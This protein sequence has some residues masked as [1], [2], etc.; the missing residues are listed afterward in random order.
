M[1]CR[2][3]GKEIPNDSLICNYCGAHQTGAQQVSNS[4]DGP[5]GALGILCFLFPIL[6]LILYLVWKDPM[7]IKA[8]GAGKAALWGFIVGIVLWIIWVIIIAATASSG[9]Y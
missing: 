6:G 9:Y 4:N 1:F 5:I 2:N 7:P 8:K 3:C